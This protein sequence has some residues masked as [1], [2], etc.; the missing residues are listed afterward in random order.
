VRVA[1]LIDQ[2]K[3]RSGINVGGLFGFRPGG[4]CFGRGIFGGDGSGGS[5]ILRGDLGSGASRRGKIIGHAVH[6]AGQG[7]HAHQDQQH[8]TDLD[9]IAH[10]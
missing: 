4:N 3:I 10:G 1:K 7:H 9:G 5:L 6:P 8:G 2:R